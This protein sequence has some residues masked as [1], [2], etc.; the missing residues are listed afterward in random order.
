[1]EDDAQQEADHLELGEQ[2]REIRDRE[3]HHAHHD[4]HR[5][6]AHEEQQEAVD[7]ERDQDDLDDVRPEARDEEAV[8]FEVHRE[9]VVAH[10][11]RS[12]SRAT[13]ASWTRTTRA[14]RSHRAAA[15]RSSAATSAATW[16]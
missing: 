14:P 15:W 13:A 1:G 2:R 4:L 5:P 12:A 9:L 16:P 8:G 7:H 10:A 6:G 3:D 11:T